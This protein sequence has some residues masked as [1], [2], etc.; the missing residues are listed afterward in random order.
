[1]DRST[2]PTATT[3][4][5]SRERSLAGFAMGDFLELAT[6]AANSS[7][8][9]AKMFIY[10]VKGYTFTQ[11]FGCSPYSFEPYNSTSACNFHNGIDLAAAVLHADQGRRGWN[12][13][14]R[15]LVRLR[16]GLL[17]H[18]RSRQWLPDDLWAYGGAAVCGGGPACGAGRDDW[19]GREHRALHRAACPLHHRAE[20]GRYRSIGRAVARC[21]HRQ[22]LAT[23]APPAGAP[24]AFLRDQQRPR[25]ELMGS[26]ALA[27]HGFRG[28]A[29]VG[30][31]CTG[32]LVASYATRA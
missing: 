29:D 2:T 4:I 32:L 24:V 18:D 15:W 20:R 28:A 9:S 8:A 19:A 25:I 1:M 13:N 31:A 3:G 30:E 7:A 26:Y 10:P 23:G 27:E 21:S 16:T 6:A 11:A 12:G 5:T 14:C 17:R 22:L